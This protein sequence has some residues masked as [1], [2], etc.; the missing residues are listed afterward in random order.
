VFSKGGGLLE[1][2]TFGTQSLQGHQE[3]VKG[4]AL[5]SLR[6]AGEEL[7]GTSPVFA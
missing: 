2:V 6:Q 3:N 7:A 1:G 5:L 4:F